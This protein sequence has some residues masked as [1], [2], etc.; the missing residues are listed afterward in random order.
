M[1]AASAASQRATAATSL[2]T[3]SEAHAETLDEFLALAGTKYKVPVFE[4]QRAATSKEYYSVFGCEAWGQ[5]Q[6]KNSNQ[7]E[8]DPSKVVSP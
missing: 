4:K 6:M 7:C 5:K 1:L 3:C 8:A 2:C